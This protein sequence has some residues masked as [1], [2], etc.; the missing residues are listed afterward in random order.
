MLIK[1]EPL[2]DLSRFVQHATSPVIHESVIVQVGGGATISCSGTIL[3]SRSEKLCRTL[4]RT[5]EIILGKSFL[6]K[7][8]QVKEVG[9]ESAVNFLTNLV[10]NP[11]QWP[12]Y[13]TVPTTALPELC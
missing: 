10:R 3:A 4:S 7:L 13:F 2:G 8:N 12:I 1:L 11:G 6:G 5:Y 9:S